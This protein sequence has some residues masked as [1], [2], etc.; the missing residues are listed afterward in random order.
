MPRSPWWLAALAATVASA[1]AASTASADT[2]T[3]FSCKGPTAAPNGA[4]GWG[5]STQTGVGHVANACPTA[6]PLS[7]SIDTDPSGTASAT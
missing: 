7:A 1:L 6:G 5:A 4:V 2:Y 3:V